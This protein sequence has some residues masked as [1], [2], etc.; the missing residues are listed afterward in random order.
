MNNNSSQSTNL[1]TPNS[2]WVSYFISNLHERVNQ[3]NFK[4]HCIWD[5][6][7]KFTLI[8]QFK[9]SHQFS[10]VQYEYYTIFERENRMHEVGLLFLGGWIWNPM[11]YTKVLIAKYFKSRRAMGRN[12]LRKEILLYIYNQAAK[13][14]RKEAA[15]TMNWFLVRGFRYFGRPY[16]GGQARLLLFRRGNSWFDC[17]QWDYDHGQLFLNKL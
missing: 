15:F 11:L 1:S 6:K 3:C 17:S 9:S 2:L 13:T 10:L 4:Y 16:K 14:T 12:D 8:D 7:Y 5:F